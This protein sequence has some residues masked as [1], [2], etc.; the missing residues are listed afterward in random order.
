MTITSIV[1]RLNQETSEG[2][3]CLFQKVVSGKMRS[4][5]EEK[6]GGNRGKST[7][8]KNQE[9]RTIL[10]ETSNPRHV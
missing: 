7:V 1:S 5:E 3:K 8:N 2:N 10:I 4:S 9:K 6:K